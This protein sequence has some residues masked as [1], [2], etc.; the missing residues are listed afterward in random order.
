MVEQKDSKSYAVEIFEQINTVRKDPKSLIPFLEDCLKHFE[1]DCL[2][3]PHFKNGGL[4]FEE[5]VKGVR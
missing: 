3:M 2:Y 4:Q 5:G 1:G